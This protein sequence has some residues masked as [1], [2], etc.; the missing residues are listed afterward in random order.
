MTQELYRDEFLQQSIHS[1]QSKSMN[2]WMQNKTMNSSVQ[3]QKPAALAETR[4]SPQALINEK[5]ELHDWRRD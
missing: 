4:E 2:R 1:N 5:I 3:E